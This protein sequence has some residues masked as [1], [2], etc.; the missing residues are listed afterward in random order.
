MN[1]DTNK[2]TAR[3]YTT[4]VSTLGT[5]HIHLRNPYIVAWWSAAFPGFGHLF[6]SRN[7]SGIL[8]I[9]WELVVN[10]NANINLAI[11]YSFQGEIDQAIHVLDTRWLLVYT[12][13]YF[14]VIWDSYRLTIDMNKMFILAEREAHR[15]N[16]FNISALGINF[17]DKRNPALAMLW[18]LFLPGLGQLYIHRLGTAFLGVL[19]ATICF[20]LSHALEAGLLL[21]LGEVQ[22]ATSV[23]KS[24]WLLFLPSIYGFFMF[25]AYIDTVENNKLFK[26]EQQQFLKDNFQPPHFEIQKN[27]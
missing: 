16:S 10:L 6:L 17:F 11:I 21:I 18:S 1:R 26:K 15:F 3:R 23:L 7:L 5:T 4:H 8:L 2:N 12:P 14:F 25:D 27:K 9:V 13:V 22:Q 24:R 20:Y 19:S